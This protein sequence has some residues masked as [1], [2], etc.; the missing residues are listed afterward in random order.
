MNF[1]G[2]RRRPKKRWLDI[3]ENMRT[4]GVCVGNVENRY[5]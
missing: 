5:V 4:V 2:K 3:I 1:E